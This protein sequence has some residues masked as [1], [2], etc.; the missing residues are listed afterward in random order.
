[1]PYPYTPNETTSDQNIISASKD[2]W[3]DDQ[4]LPSAIRVRDCNL[5]DGPNVE[6]D[7]FDHGRSHAEI[8]KVLVPG[9][10]E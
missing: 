3:N 8:W 9:E 2:A 5:P 7:G 1:M 4:N 6:Y 10:F